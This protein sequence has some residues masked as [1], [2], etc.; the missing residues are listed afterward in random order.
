MR[1][2]RG[3]RKWRYHLVL[4]VQLW[5]ALVAEARRRR[6]RVSHVMWERLRASLGITEG[7]GAPREVLGSQ[8]AE[9]GNRCH[10][11][12]NQ[13]HP[14]SPIMSQWGPRPGPSQLVRLLPQSC[15]TGGLPRRWAAR[16]CIVCSARWLPPAISTGPWTI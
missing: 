6:M 11:S 14:G 9:K 4:S 1:G 12:P 13:S 8:P 15:F 3:P 5:D 10:R 16:C 7:G 2:D